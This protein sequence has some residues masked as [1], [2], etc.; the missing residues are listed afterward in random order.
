MPHPLRFGVCFLEWSVV[1]MLVIAVRRHVE[2]N[3]AMPHGKRKMLAHAML[4]RMQD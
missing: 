4:E 1:E 3:C 2:L